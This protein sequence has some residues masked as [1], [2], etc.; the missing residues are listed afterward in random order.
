MARPRPEP[1][2]ASSARTPRRSTRSRIDGSALPHRRPRGSRREASAAVA[3]TTTRD[4]AHLHALS[5][6]LPSISSR[7]SAGTRTTTVGGHVD[8]D[9]RARG[10]RTAAASCGP[11]RRPRS[12]T[13]VA[14][15]GVAPAAVDA[16]LR[17]VRVDL[18]AHPLDLLANRRR[19]FVL[20][21]G[22]RPV[23]LLREDG[24]RRLQAVRQ[25]AGLGQRARD[26]ALA[27]VEQRVEVLDERRD[28]ARIVA[29]EPRASARRGRRRVVRA[30]CGTETGRGGSPTVPPVASRW[31][32]R[33]SGTR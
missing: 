30:A 4:V 8:G 9:R 27:L 24:E 21:G 2:V 12:A 22:L 32:H 19:Q 20:P 17:E 7:S 10:R 25:V 33:K 28:L 6:R 31:R 3:D 15:L 13:F 26:A 1:G 18:P 5:S 16:R 14:A 23:D 11:G 29:L